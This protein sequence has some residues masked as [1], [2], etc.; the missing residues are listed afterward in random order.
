MR[1]LK[2]NGIP[3]ERITCEKSVPRIEYLAAHA[4]VDI[5]LDTFP[6]TGGT[7]T[8]EALWMGV[9]TLTLLGES[10]IGRQGASLLACA[11]MKDWICKD[12]EEYVAKAAA[13]AADLE[14]LAKLRTGLRQK[15]MASPLFDGPRFARDF[16]AAMLGMW[17]SYKEKN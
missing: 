5:I 3:S 7:T 10:M 6:F 16:E 11:G 13:Y 9:P 12:E 14:N 17:L 4:N 8:C 1:R 15:I 2:F